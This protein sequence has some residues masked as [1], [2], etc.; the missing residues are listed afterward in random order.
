MT[1]PTIFVTGGAGYVGSHCCKAFA[2]AG[3]NVV[4]YDDLS[5]GWRDFVK[6]GP[7]IEGDIRDAGRLSAAVREHRPDAVA[8]FAAVAYVGESVANPGLYYD[9]NTGGSLNLLRAMVASGVK[10]IVFSSSCATYGVPERMPVA[11]DTPQVPISPYGASKLMAERMLRDFGQA[12]AI[13]SVALRYFNAAGADPGGEL[14]ERHFPETHLIPL[15]IEAARPGDARLTVFGDDLATADG[16]CVRDYVHVADLA[17]AHVLAMRH[18]LAGG[19]SEIFNLG[20]ETGTSV[21]EVIAAVERVGGAPVR[22]SSG[23]AR[24]GDPPVLVASAA[25]A[26]RALGWRPRR[27]GIAAIV[28]DA[29][30]WHAA[31]TPAPDTPASP[32]ASR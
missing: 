31:D 15:A 1:Q 3:W 27:S 25:K 5:R 22:N 13:R 28:A 10:R 32:E 17:D 8:H 14:G 16:T 9:I 12:H 4:T 20:T 19:A 2:Q 24:E 18:L 7:L 30:R 11:E 21:R 26:R 29:W 6:W 23:A